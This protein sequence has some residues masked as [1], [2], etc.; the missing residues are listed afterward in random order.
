MGAAREKE[1]VARFAA[2]LS[3]AAEDP[4]PFLDALA[5]IWGVPG[6]VS[7]PME[8]GFTDFYEDEMGPGLARRFVLFK[9]PAPAD[10]LREWKIEANALEG[11]FAS[12]GRRHLN[13]DPGYLDSGGVVVA[14]VKDAASRVYL[15][16]G[17]YAQP[18]LRF[19]RGSFRAWPW[20]YPDYA[21][22][23]AI[24][25]FNASRLVYRS[26]SRRPTVAHR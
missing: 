7:A 12:G 8:F 16:K 3:P 26:A 2:L 20:T 5:G 11:R 17:I 19:E 13:A 22:P 25:F 1:P 6:L 9:D 23:A 21:S 4:G 15:G 24:G 10:G 18:M 14:S